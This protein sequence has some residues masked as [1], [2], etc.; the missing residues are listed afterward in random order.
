MAVDNCCSDMD[1]T[2][3]SLVFSSLGSVDFGP[4]PLPRPPVRRRGLRG[5]DGAFPVFVEEAGA[6]F[7]ARPLPRGRLPPPPRVGAVDAE[8]VVLWTST[9]AWWFPWLILGLLR[10]FW[11]DPSSP[12][13]SAV[14]GA[15]PRPRPPRPP[16]RPRPRPRPSFPRFDPLLGGGGTA[17]SLIKQTIAISFL[18]FQQM[19]H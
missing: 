4:R 13:P 7:D 12:P 8:E 17:L 1:G 15:R 5:L 10:L 11:V 19:Y 16:L 2:V 14:V 9:L 3:V 18:S 6:V